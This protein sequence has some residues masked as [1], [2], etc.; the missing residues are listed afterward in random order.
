MARGYM[1]EMLLQGNDTMHGPIFQMVASHAT[2]NLP[3]ESISKKIMPNH[4]KRN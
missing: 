1:A 3:P 4:K 2:P